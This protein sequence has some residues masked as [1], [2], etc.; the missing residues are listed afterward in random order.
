MTAHYIGTP[1]KLSQSEIYQCRIYIRKHRGKRVI[2]FHNFFIDLEA[3]SGLFNL[4]CSNCH[5]AHFHSCCEKGRPLAPGKET[6]KQLTPHVET[7]VE[8]YLTSSH[9]KQW[10]K[11][12]FIERSEK[13]DYYDNFSLCG[14]DCFFYAKEQE[15]F[16][17][18]HRYAIEQQLPLT[19]LKPMACSMYPIDLIEIDGCILI[20]AL[21]PETL[22]FCR[23]GEEYY[24]DFLCANV[25]YREDSMN[26]NQ[27]SRENM[28]QSIPESI[29]RL[30]HYKPAYVWEKETIE[31]FCGKEVY[32]WIDTKI[33]EN[34]YFQ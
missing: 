28:R 7:I 21:H 23:W 11:E 2:S 31:H 15:H 33:K 29:F 20:T 19:S 34:D 1:E 10:R 30:D 26:G 12:G 24:K 17:S 8:R 6:I 5:L 16:C 4:D 18:I 13:T 27:E 25:Q 3:L 9:E 14:E 22:S 32:E